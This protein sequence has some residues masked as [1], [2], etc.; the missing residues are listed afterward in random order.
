LSLKP[1]AYLINIS[2]NSSSVK[3]KVKNYCRLDDLFVAGLSR[4]AIKELFYL[5]L[6]DSAQFEVPGFLVDLEQHTR[7]IEQ[8]IHRFGL[9]SAKSNTKSLIQSQFFTGN[10]TNIILANE[11][12]CIIKKS[13]IPSKHFD[14]CELDC[15]LGSTKL[16]IELK[17]IYATG[18]L[19]DYIDEVDAKF[20]V[21][22]SNEKSLVKNVL[23]V[24]IIILDAPSEEKLLE[25]L[26]DGYRSLFGKMQA[27]GILRKDFQFCIVGFSKN[28]DFDKFIKAVHER[29]VS[30]I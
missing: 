21:M 20:K 12:R 24:F 11:L 10:I 7:D 27:K 25:R 9:D 29:V 16:Y 18:N 14:N 4:P 1:R 26:I 2:A 19:C 15:Y 30:V 8:F 17:R 6:F 28:S 3:H 5:S 13:I 23:F 22:S